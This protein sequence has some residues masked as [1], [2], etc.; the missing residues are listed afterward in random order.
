MNKNTLLQSEN[1]FQDEEVITHRRLIFQ[2][3]KLGQ[4]HDAKPFDE[5][6]VL[7]LYKSTS[8]VGASPWFD[9]AGMLGAM[10][11]KSYLA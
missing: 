9:N 6:S 2:Q 4:S 5:L 11:L 1:L 10:F 7:L 3:S 8:P